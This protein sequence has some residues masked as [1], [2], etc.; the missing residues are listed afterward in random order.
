M[1]VTGIGP[2]DPKFAR[3]QRKFDA[4]GARAQTAVRGAVVLRVGAYGRPAV[5]S[6]ALAIVYAAFTSPGA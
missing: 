3:H 2:D 4:A 1:L 5:H 6:A